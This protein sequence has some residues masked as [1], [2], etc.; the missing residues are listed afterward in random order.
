MRSWSTSWRFLPVSSRRWLF[1]V[2]KKNSRFVVFHSLQV[3]IW[4]A[5]YVVIF[6]V[7]MILTLFS[8]LFRSSAHPH[9][10]PANRRLWHFLAFSGSCGYGEWAG[11]CST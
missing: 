1:S 6:V 5:A 11:G 10:A 4:Q 7:G 2:L 3:L 8:C 9:P